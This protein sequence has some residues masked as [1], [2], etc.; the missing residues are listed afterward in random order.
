MYSIHTVCTGVLVEHVHVDRR[1]GHAVLH[2]APAAAVACQ[3]LPLGALSR[4]P[5]RVR[6]HE[7]LLRAAR[8]P[9]CC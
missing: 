5:N 9:R 2:A 7:R 3:T 4:W 1:V 6:R 8:R